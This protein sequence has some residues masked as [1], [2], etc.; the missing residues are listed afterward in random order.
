M[1]P[2]AVVVEEARNSKQP[3]RRLLD[4]SHLEVVAETPREPVKLLRGVDLWQDTSRLGLVGESGS[5]KSMTA[6]AI[7]GLLP[8]AI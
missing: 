2:E 3:A 4:I 6:A 5:G 8:P 7:L 1:R